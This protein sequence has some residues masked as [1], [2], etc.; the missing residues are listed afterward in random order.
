MTQRPTYSTTK[1]AIWINTG[2]AWVVVILLAA[3][4]VMG[5]EQAVAM[6]NIA[7]PSMVA[8]IAGTLGIHRHYGS[9]D[10][11]AGQ[12]RDEPHPP[13]MPRDQPGGPR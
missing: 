12:E 9:R 6:A 3:G 11:A 8:L 1:R 13:Y 5:S 2:F 7:L 4:A 10:F